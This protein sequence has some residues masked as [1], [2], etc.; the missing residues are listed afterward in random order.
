[1]ISPQ[2][3]DRLWWNL[4]WWCIWGD[5]HNSSVIKING[6]WKCKAAICKIV[7]SAQSLDQFHWNLAQKCTSTLCTSSAYNSSY[8]QIETFNFTFAQQAFIVYFYRAKPVINGSVQNKRA[9]A[10]R[11]RY[12]MLHSV[13]LHCCYWR[14]APEMSVTFLCIFANPT[15]IS[16]L[17]VS[18]E[19]NE[20]PI[21]MIH[22]PYAIL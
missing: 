9:A 10:T 21:P 18:S 2:P 12:L 4:A 15:S 8:I 11:R 5:L 20:T 14:S 16:N 7:I 6:I 13:A 17:T 3:L 22:C 19:S 1:M